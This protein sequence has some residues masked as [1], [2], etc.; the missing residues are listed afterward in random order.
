MCDLKRMEPGGRDWEGKGCKYLRPELV[1]Y[2]EG[3][4][5]KI[6]PYEKE[7]QKSCVC[8]GEIHT[9]VKLTFVEI[10]RRFSWSLE[11]VSDLGWVTV[12]WTIGPRS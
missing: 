10:M 1:C 12:S 2:M 6:S 8:H 11:E 3:W 5:L 9:S 4:M 7:P